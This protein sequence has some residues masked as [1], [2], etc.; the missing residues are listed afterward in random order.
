MKIPSG[1]GTTLGSLAYLVSWD[2]T[3]KS[4]KAQ[5]RIMCL[6]FMVH[7]CPGVGLDYFAWTRLLKFW[8]TT[9]GFEHIVVSQS[10]WLQVYNIIRVPEIW[11]V[12]MQRDTLCNVHCVLGTFTE[13]TFLILCFPYLFWFQCRADSLLFGTVVFVTVSLLVRSPKDMSGWSSFAFS[14]LVFGNEII[15]THYCSFQ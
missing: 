11:F 3:S 2:T 9:I 8:W 14:D 7:G 5:I 4:K 10:P 6:A 12:Q 13:P 1:A 15:L